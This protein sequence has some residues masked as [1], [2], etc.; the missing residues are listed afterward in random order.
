MTL[1]LAAGAMMI[2]SGSIHAVVNAVIKSGKNKMA[3][4]AMIDGTAALIL[5]PGI[6]FVPLP[7][8]AWG[9][10]IASTAIHALYL[11]AVVRTYELADFSAAYPIMRGLAP[12]LTATVSLALLH[13]RGTTAQI[14]GIAIVAAGILLLSLG[15]HL[16]GQALRW[17]VICG[18][19]T[20]AYTV[21]DAHGVR[22]APTVASFIVW[23]FVLMGA[24]IVAQ[25]AAMTRGAV[26]ADMRHQWL[27]GS[28]AGALSIGTYG[29]A[30]AAFARGPTA[31]LAALRE[32]GMVTALLIGVLW[33]QE[34]VTKRRVAAMAAILT[35]ASLIL[36][37]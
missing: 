34:P 13:E 10:L 23:D 15:K 17:A 3:G 24:M 25:F 12:P 35:G 27:P 2:A 5:L 18:C 29:L 4:R 22:A 1:P 33:L 11:L 26:F 21:A 14:A 30:L 6:L 28:I 16:S 9:W 36:V 32:T 31:P 7:H 8:G 20:A 37:H 19:C